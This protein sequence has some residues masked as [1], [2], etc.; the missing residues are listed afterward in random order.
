MQRWPGTHARAEWTSV[1][2]S[3]VLG[4][5][6][7]QLG[8]WSVAGKVMLARSTAGL[9]KAQDTLIRT[10]GIELVRTLGVVLGLEGV[11]HAHTTTNT[12]AQVAS[13]DMISQSQKHWSSKRAIDAG[14]MDT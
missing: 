4:S 13:F 3:Q 1:S 14:A 10:H 12:K 5:P 9:L 7:L 6:S 8:A 2:E 11:G